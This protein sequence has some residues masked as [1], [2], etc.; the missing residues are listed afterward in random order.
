MLFE[1]KPKWLLLSTW[2]ISS[3]VMAN[4]T[5]LA[6]K[7]IADFPIG[8]AVPV[9]PW[10][11]SLLRSK[12]RQALVEKH[13]SSLT[14]ENGMKMAYLQPRPGEFEFTHADALVNYAKSHGLVVHGHAL[15]WHTQAAPWMDEYQ[16][17]AY[18]FTEMLDSHVRNV[19]T[20]F[21]GKL[22]SWDV[23]NEAFTDDSPSDYRPTIWFNNIGP[24]YIERA[25]R[26]AR[27]ADPN[28]ELYY[29]DY[30]ISGAVP[31]KLDR[32]LAMLDDFLARGVPID[33]LGFQ[34]HI[35]TE[36]PSLEAIRDAFS[37]AAKRGIKVRISE[38]DI[39][40]NQS[41][42]YDALSPAVAELQAKRYQ[43]VIQA[44]LDTVPPKLRGGIT[45][46]GLTDGDS[47][48]PGF[49][50]RQDWPLLFDDNFAD[51]PAL[52]GM[53]NGLESQP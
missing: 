40:V 22:K 19:A 14:A 12:Q 53:A 9:D 26:L 2:L 32:V 37:R 5:P 11:N 45:V 21:A 13:F 4:V 23:V 51:K 41:E 35:D 10:P 44:Y 42:Q 7:S 3:A 48:I 43:Q 38:L 33:G 17:P 1:F 28:V 46:W 25:F 49:K 18:R 15:V 27:E 31:A 29:N 36:S 34:V 8:V 24:G 52:V 16:G 6:L 30:N 20:H 39:A 47:W 50:Q